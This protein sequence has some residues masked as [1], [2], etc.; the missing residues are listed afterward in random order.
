MGG[1]K[2][3]F[4]SFLLTITFDLASSGSVDSFNVKS[5]TL[6]CLVPLG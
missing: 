6:N 2:I 5:H 1:S 4:I 3:C